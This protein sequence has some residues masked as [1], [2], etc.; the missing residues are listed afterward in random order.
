MHLLYLTLVFTA[1]S[2][3]A[4][5]D[6]VKKVLII[7]DT[8]LKEGEGLLIQAVYNSTGLKAVFSD[9]EGTGTSL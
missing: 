7:H 6:D 8:P 4:A 1:F 2:C 3:A 5:A 9:F